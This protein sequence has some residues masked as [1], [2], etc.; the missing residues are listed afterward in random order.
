MIEVITGHF[1]AEPVAGFQPLLNGWDI[2]RNRDLEPEK[3][4]NRTLALPDAGRT[5]SAP[6]IPAEQPSRS[7][8]PG[9]ERLIFL[10][11]EKPAFDR[12]R[13]VKR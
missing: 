2:G 1:L 8:Q 11:L 7:P 6:S 13:E 12:D 10:D 9:R 3:V 5:Q 4:E